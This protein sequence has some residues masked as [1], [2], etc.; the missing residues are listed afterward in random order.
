[1]TLYEFGYYYYYYYY[2]TIITT[3]TGEYLFCFV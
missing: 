1:M 2:F 3:T